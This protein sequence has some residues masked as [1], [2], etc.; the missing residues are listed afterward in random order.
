MS[1]VLMLAAIACASLAGPDVVAENQYGPQE[2]KVAAGSKIVVSNQ[3]EFG[4]V[5]VTGWDSDMVQATA[6]SKNPRGPVPLRVARDLFDAK[7]I[8]VTTAPEAEGS[9]SSE[10]RLEVKVPRYVELE[11]VHVRKADLEITDVDGFV[12]VSSGS[13]SINL[14]RDGSVKV[15]SGSG[16][17][18]VSDVSG[19]V[20]VQ[21]GSGTFTVKDV[22]GSL[23][24]KFGS[25]IARIANIGGSIDVTTSTGNVEIENAESDVLVVSINGNTNIRC[26]TGRIEVHDTSG[27]ITLA[28]IKGDVDVTTSNGRATFTGIAYADRRYRLKTLSGAVEMAVSEDTVGF[29]ATLSSYSRRVETDFELKSETSLP[30]SGSDRRVVGTYGNGRSRIELDS[31]NGRVRLSKI[32]SNAIPKCER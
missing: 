7:R 27:V 13:G 17:V 1:L 5:V 32:A 24:A 9:G 28:G 25:G 30:T 6:V 31:F 26:A 19:S 21:K 15:S 16:D 11:V 2:L 8:S 12:A 23:T 14:R 18:V 29:T 20:S 4:S 10:V 3:F 22:K